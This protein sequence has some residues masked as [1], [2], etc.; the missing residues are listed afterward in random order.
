LGGSTIARRRTGAS[1]PKA[2]DSEVLGAE[3]AEKEPDKTKLV[4]EPK[5][6]KEQK[7][8][9]EPIPAKERK[10]GKKKKKA[11]KEKKAVETFKVK[12]TAEESK[13]KEA[14]KEYSNRILPQKPEE[15][16]ISKWSDDKARTVPFDVVDATAVTKGRGIFGIKCKPTA[17]TG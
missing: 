6:V 16:M 11:L 9:K 17:N 2:P 10:P 8:E 12:E 1:A 14:G 7:P 3:Q 5:P 13:F 4:K 15:D